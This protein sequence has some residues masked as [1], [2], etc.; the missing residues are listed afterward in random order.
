MNRSFYS[1][2]V[3]FAGLYA[4]IAFFQS[5]ISLQLGM[6][7]Y[8]LQS[9]AAWYAC[10]NFISLIWSLI[11]LKYYHYKKYE[12]TFWAVIISSIAVLIQFVIVFNLLMGARE[13][14]NYYIPAILLVLGA[15]ILS[16]LSLIFSNAGKRPWLKAAG[17]FTFFLGLIVASAFIWGMNSPDFQKNSTVEKIHQWAS[18]VG[19]FAPVLFIMNFLSELNIFNKENAD[20]PRPTR[21]SLESLMPAICLIALVT[22]LIFGSNVAN[23]SLSLIAWN[24]GAPERAQ[25]LAQPFEARKYV[26]SQGET[27]PYR[28]LKPPDY[29]ST[30]KYPLVVCLHHGGT[31]GTDN[32]MQIEG[33]EPAQVLYQNRIKYPAFL[34]VPQCPKG[35]SWGGIPDIPSIDSLV[36]ETIKSLEVEFEIDEKRRYAIGIS[37]GGYGSWYFISTRPEMFAA[38]IPICGGGDPKLAQ[39]MADVP[40]WAFHGEKDR[41]VPVSG[42]RDMIEA[43]KKAG[44]N[45]RYTEFPDAGHNIWG[46][47]YNTPGLLDWLFGQKRK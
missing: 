11:Q 31:H 22:M 20:S 29:D 38:A 4:L 2:A 40:V 8:T 23:E 32:L 46:Q 15:G 13:L 33:S 19:S 5:V 27:M 35:S 37:G 41:N 1:F 10:V 16:A 30:K 7:T 47:V 25:R 26:N 34:F 9:F 39:N 17:V 42:S 12:V 44:G 45:P 28:L 18:M 36:F 21:R 6:Q 3:F 43:I 24:K 14:A